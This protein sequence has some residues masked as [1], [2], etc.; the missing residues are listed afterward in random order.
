MNSGVCFSLVELLYLC[1]TS[2]ALVPVQQPVPQAR[3]KG[4]LG[5]TKPHS[6]TRNFKIG[7]RAPKKCL[8]D[9]WIDICYGLWFVLWFMYTKQSF[10]QLVICG[11]PMNRGK[12][13]KYLC[14][15]LC[16]LGI[17]VTCEYMCIQFNMMQCNN[18]KLKYNSDSGNCQGSVQ[19]RRR[20]L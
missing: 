2:C 11:L 15:V 12:Q 17:T 14:W 4:W 18:H 5:I 19:S 20:G 8:S 3:G 13:V 1:V 7:I 16:W 9:L 6:L 10:G